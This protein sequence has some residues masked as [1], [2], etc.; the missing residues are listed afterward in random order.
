MAKKIVLAYSGGL[1]TSVAV[2]WLKE[3]GYEVICFMANVGQAQDLKALSLRAR[4]AGA[5]RVIVRDLRREFAKSYIGPAI[6]ANAIYEGKYVLA[7]ALARPLIAKELVRCARA[8]RARAV[9]HGSTGKGND[10]VRF[11][12]AIRMLAQELEIVA[13]VR[14]WELRSREEEIDYALRRKIPLDVTKKSPYSIDQ[15]LWG[16]SIESG[17]LEDPWQEPPENCFI[18]TRGYARRRMRPQRVTIGFTRGI[19]LSLNGRNYEPVALI[20]K[21]NRLGARFGIGRTDMIENRLVGIKSREVYE[22]P[23]AWI[24]LTAHQDLESLTLDRWLYQY[25]LGLIPLYARLIYEGLWFTDLKRSLDRFIDETQ[26][27]VT[28]KVRLLLSPGRVM[29]TGRASPHSLYRESLATYSGKDEFDQS[30]AKGF[31][32]LFDP[33]DV[34][35]EAYAAYS[36]PKAQKRSTL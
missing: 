16:V 17:V 5:S 12:L 36:P 8:E 30:L 34:V 4:R 22:A 3:Q 24:I 31:I 33:G 10:Q 32:E 2:A 28:G 26:K 11:E 35:E 15:N 25:K 21:L 14:E 20:E 18:W 27:R 9:A 19:P 13:P 7:T 29:V 23:A 6:K 1:D